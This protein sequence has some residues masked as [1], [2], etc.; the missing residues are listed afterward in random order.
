MTYYHGSP[1][2]NL[3]ELIPFVS[4]HQKSYIY[5]AT[6][7]LVALLYSVKPVPKPFSFYPYGFD[8]N[9][10]LIYS[11]YFPN[12]F[13]ELYNGKTGYLYEV[14]NLS[15]VENPTNINS[16]V[17]CE[18]P[19]KID[20]VTKISNVYEYYMQKEKSGEFRIKKNKDISANEMNFILTE[21]KKDIENYKLY[22]YPNNPM[23]IFLR[24]NFSSL[25]Y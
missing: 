23:S 8:Q 15:A 17:V 1:I 7:P 25:F 6:N 18:N 4:E 10:T 20:N 12:A 21:L 9:N 16:A 14:D 11:E 13:Y 19:I 24:K 3:K 22:D 5:F 2:G